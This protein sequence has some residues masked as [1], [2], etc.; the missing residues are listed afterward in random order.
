MQSL[1]CAK[2]TDKGTIASLF[3]KKA[4]DRITITISSFAD[5]IKSIYSFGFGIDINADIADFE[6]SDDF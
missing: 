3:Q 5:I 1:V 6:E 4:N 2:I